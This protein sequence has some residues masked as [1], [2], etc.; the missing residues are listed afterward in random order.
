MLA[1]DFYLHKE[2]LT[3]ITKLIIGVCANRIVAVLLPKYKI[4]QLGFEARTA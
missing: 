3:F 2:S 1:S 4:L